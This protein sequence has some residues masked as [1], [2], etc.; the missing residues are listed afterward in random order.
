MIT[1]I[2]HAPHEE[3]PRLIARDVV[4]NHVVAIE[5]DVRWAIAAD[6]RLERG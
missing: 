2:V 1:Q 5:V 6:K 3:V 4:G